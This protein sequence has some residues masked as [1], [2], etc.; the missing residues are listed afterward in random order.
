[1][2]NFKLHKRLEKTLS[3]LF[4]KN[5]ILYEQV[6]K[7]IDEVVNCFDV[8]HYKN[9]R[10]PLNKYKRVH[11]GSFVLVFR[12]DKKENLVWFEAFEHHDFVY[13]LGYL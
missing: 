1:M 6:W 12:Y 3:K 4:K 11:V 9:L 5:K 8:E 10:S 7:K 2:Y 13:E